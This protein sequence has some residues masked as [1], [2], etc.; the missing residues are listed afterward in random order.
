[1]EKTSRSTFNID[2]IHQGRKMMMFLTTPDF[3]EYKSMSIENQVIVAQHIT[4][5]GSYE[6][7]KL[8]IK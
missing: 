7:A 3:E 4:N 6:N 1:M 8:L 2:D 5:G